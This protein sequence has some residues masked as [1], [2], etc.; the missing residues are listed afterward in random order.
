MDSELAD[1]HVLATAHRSASRNRRHVAVSLDHEGRSR[2]SLGS[3]FAV[4]P[5]SGIFGVNGKRFNEAFAS[6]E[7]EVTLV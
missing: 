1:N 6:G 3:T 4:A 7:R 2:V 5:A